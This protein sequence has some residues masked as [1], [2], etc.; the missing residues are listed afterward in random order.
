MRPSEVKIAFL[1]LNSS[2]V[3]KPINEGS[4]AL[5]NCSQIEA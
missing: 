4:F 5:S 2:M 1:Q 3:G